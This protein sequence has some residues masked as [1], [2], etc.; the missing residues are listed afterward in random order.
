MVLEASLG[1]SS[2]NRELAALKAGSYTAAGA[3]VL[4][5]VALACGL[6]VSGAGASALAPCGLCGAFCRTQFMEFH[7]RYLLMRFLRSQP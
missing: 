5:L 2:V 6:A 4:A 1:M 3:S 7:L